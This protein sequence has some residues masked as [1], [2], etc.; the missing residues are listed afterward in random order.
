MCVVKGNVVMV[1][2]EAE[3]RGELCVSIK[4][5][6]V[7]GEI[8]KIVLRNNTVYIKVNDVYNG[9]VIVDVLKPSITPDKVIILFEKAYDGYIFFS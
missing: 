4:D 6:I 1:C 5:E 8:Y 7:Y 9:Y 3:K 2:E